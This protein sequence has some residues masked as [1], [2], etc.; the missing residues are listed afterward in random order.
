MKRLSKHVLIL[1]LSIPSL[2]Y[3]Q[4]QSYEVSIKLKDAPNQAT[5]YLISNYGNYNQKVID[6]AKITQGQFNFQGE[7]EEPKLVSIVINHE[8]NNKIA[9]PMKSDNKELFLESGKILIS[10]RDSIKHAIFTSKLNPINKKFQ[11]YYQEVIQPSNKLAEKEGAFFFSATEEERKTEEFDIKLLSLISK[12][13][14][15]KKNLAFNFFRRNPESF[16]SFHFLKQFSNNKFDQEEYVDQFN[17]LSPTLKKYPSVAQVNKYI[18]N[19]KKLAIGKQAPVFIQRDANGQMINFL[20]FRGKYVLIDFWASWCGP[21]RK[22]NPNV[23]AAYEKFKSKNFT[24]LG[25]SLD[26]ENQKQNWI[27]AIERDGLAWSNVSD[28]KG[29]KNEAAVLYNVNAIPTNFLIDPNGIIIAR[30]LKGED[31]HRFLEKQL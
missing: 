21:C 31:L 20:D 5:A 25:I 12:I 29:W 22:E 17:R 4:Q 24:V 11:R 7:V 6:S 19:Q 13:S 30:N 3:A 23:L 1:C 10:G 8:V 27:E 18:E 15:Y 16:V 26:N 2:S 9:L 14:F 28:L